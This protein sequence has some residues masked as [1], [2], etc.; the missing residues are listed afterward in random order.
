MTGAMPRRMGNEHPL[1]APSGAVRTRDGLIT[2]TVLD[3]QWRAFCNGL[4]I[5]SLADD[6][7]F[8]TSGGRQSH[9]EA[10]N[11]V[12]EP[13]FERRMSKEWLEVLRGIDVLCSRINDYASLV[14]DP[15]VEHNGLIGVVRDESGR[16]LPQVS[17]PVRLGSATPGQ[18]PPPRLGE[19][20]VE[21]LRSELRMG[22]ADVERLIGANIAVCP[23]RSAA[24]ATT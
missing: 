21:I 11:A 1:I 6:P 9:R 7:R 10:L 23:G 12:L 17:N 15:Q 20:T 19:H 3:H 2:Y 16:E 24:G 8:A 4:G 14:H 18:R 5:G 22:D 13:I